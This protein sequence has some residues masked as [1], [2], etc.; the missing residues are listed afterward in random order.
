MGSTLKD[1][2]ARAGVSI[3]TVSNVVNDFE[4][5]SPA[6]RERVRRAIDAIGYQPN[7]PA[8]HLRKARAGVLALAIP[9]L[10][11]TYFSDIGHTV[12]EAA[13]ARSYTT[14][15]EHTGGSAP[16]KSS[17]RAGCAHT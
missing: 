9:D 11:N 8:R 17:W 10:S 5:V 14:V 6:T 15:I 13:A 12:Y 3:K 1:V 16:P 4:H 7:L 2:A